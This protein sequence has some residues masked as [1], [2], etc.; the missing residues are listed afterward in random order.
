MAT[1]PAW[2]AID[3]LPI[4]ERRRRKKS[5]GTDE[6]PEDELQAAQEKRAAALFDSHS[7]GARDDS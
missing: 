1:A 7:V 2:R 4:M 3:P 5:D 6:G